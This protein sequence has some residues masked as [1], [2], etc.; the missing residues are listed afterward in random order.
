MA[1]MLDAAQS[2]FNE[3]ARAYALWFILGS[4]WA[5]LVCEYRA[6]RRR[7]KMVAHIRV[8]ETELM[9][10]EDHYLTERTH[11]DRVRAELLDLLAAA[12]KHRP[13]EVGDFTSG[14]VA[15][16]ESS[17]ALRQEAAE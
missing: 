12:R 2:W 5:V 10:A 14:R 15:V 9:N 6:Y 1:F 16:H 17:Q 3:P 7:V 8:L 4:L 11:S 13:R